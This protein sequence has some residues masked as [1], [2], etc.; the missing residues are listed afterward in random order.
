[1]QADFA[2]EARCPADDHA[3]DV[4]APDIAGHH[5]IRDQERCCPGVVGDY[6]V[7]GQVGRAL[8]W[9]VAGHLLDDIQ[10]RGEQVGLVVG[11][12]TSCKTET[13]RSR[14]IPVSTC[15][16]GSGSSSVGLQAVVLDE[17]QVPQLQV[18]GAI[19]R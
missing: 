16:A 10:Q 1:M 14:P 3:A 2:A 13:M 4:V 17:D 6:P 15:L 19:M 7:R 12:A 9:V 18:A 5:A 8:G 11:V